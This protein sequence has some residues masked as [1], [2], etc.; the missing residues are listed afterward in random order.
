MV[1]GLNVAD[2]PVSA[3]ERNRD[4]A[5]VLGELRQNRACRLREIGGRQFAERSAAAGD[6]HVDVLDEVA[7]DVAGVVVRDG[8]VPIALT[9]VAEAGSLASPAGDVEGRE[10]RDRNR[11]RSAAAERP[12]GRQKDL[13]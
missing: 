12:E 4:R 2:E 7:D 13:D 5:V 10:A 3:I 6:Q 1:A 8:V 9:W 11:V